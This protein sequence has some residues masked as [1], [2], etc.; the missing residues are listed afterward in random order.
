MRLLTGLLLLVWLVVNLVVPWFA[1]E[2]DRDCGGGLRFSFWTLA[3]GL[4]LVY[5]LIIVAYVIGAARIDAR[6]VAALDHI[7]PTVP[8]E[9]DRARSS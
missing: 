3:Q 2:L 8:D 7:K 6:Y 9:D 5:L 4:L 1:C